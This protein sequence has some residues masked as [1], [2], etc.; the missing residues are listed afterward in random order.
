ML[1]FVAGCSGEPEKPVTKDATACAASGGDWVRACI[2][3]TYSCV[4]PY[5]DAG[6]SCTDSS[7][8]AGECIIE[9]VIR[10]E[11]NG[12]C[13][14]PVVPEPGTAVTGVCKRLPRTCG[15]VVLVEDGKAS[16]VRLHD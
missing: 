3:G 9:L 10:C 16:P 1:V 12:D 11:K 15:S 4:V 13:T 5:P 6:K 14:D 2:G 8:C 7:Q